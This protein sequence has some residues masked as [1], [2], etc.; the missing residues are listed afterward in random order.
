MSD[1]MYHLLEEDLKFE[2]H[3]LCLLRFYLVFDCQRILTVIVKPIYI[4]LSLCLTYLTLKL[5]CA[6]SFSRLYSIRQITYLIGT[7]FLLSLRIHLCIDWLIKPTR[8]TIVNLSS[9]WLASRF[10]NNFVFAR[11][12]RLVMGLTKNF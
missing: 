5:F 3:V 6:Y 2:T 1:Q 8:T 9:R 7:I 4:L 11:F 12:S 10:S